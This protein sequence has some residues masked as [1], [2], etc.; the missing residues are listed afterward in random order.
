[1]LMI[2]QTQNLTYYRTYYANAF[3]SQTSEAEFNKDD[4][5]IFQGQAIRV[6]AYLFMLLLVGE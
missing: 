5:I 6:C 1:M 2:V 4:F 3:A